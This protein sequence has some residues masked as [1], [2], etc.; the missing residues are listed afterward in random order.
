MLK[1]L[2]LASAM[3]ISVPALAQDQTTPPQTTEPAAPGREATPP[4]ETTTPPAETTEAQPASDATVQEQ[5]QTATTAEQAAQTPAQTPATPATEQPAPAEQA[6]AA[7][8]PATPAQPA[9][10]GDQVAQI[11]NTEFPSY[12]KNSDGS[13][14]K[15]EFGSWM[16][17]LK[18]A[19][20]PSTKADDPATQS[21]VTGALASADTDKSSTI[22]KEELTTYLSKGAASD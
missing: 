14:D 16:V 11:V 12:D 13:L 22:T 17:A 21:W 5:A 7:A 10:G 9:S 15:A 20:D 8:T 1:T 2:L 6:A 19:S 3:T 18:S 4:T